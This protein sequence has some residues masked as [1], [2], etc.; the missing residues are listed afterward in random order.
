MTGSVANLL[1]AMTRAMGAGTV[2]A[3]DVILHDGAGVMIVVTM[4]GDATGGA[5][6]DSA[7]RVG[8]PETIVG[9]TTTGAIDGVTTAGVIDATVAIDLCVEFR[10]GIA[11]DKLSQLRQ[12]VPIAGHNAGPI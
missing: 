3:R 8:G 2:V 7:I 10:I 12:A 6:I 9:E 1:T 4:T 5:T 11:G